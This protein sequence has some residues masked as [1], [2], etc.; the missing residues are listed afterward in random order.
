MSY[1]ELSKRWHAAMETRDKAWAEYEASLDKD[2]IGGQTLQLRVVYYEAH[3]Y[4]RALNELCSSELK[5]QRE[6][7]EPFVSVFKSHDVTVSEVPAGDDGSVTLDTCKYCQ[8]HYIDC[9]C[10]HCWLDG[11]K[12]SLDYVVDHQIWHSCEVCGLDEAIGLTGVSGH[13]GPVGEEVKDWRQ[14]IVEAEVAKD[15]ATYRAGNGWYV[16]P[17]QNCFF[18]WFVYRDDGALFTFAVTL[19]AAKRLADEGRVS[20]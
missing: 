4:A 6:N 11:H 3:G 16:T 9:N 12:W 13:V 15:G 2:G 8:R 17:S 7:S 20:R 5:Q 19:D 1:E 14:E 10:D 18:D